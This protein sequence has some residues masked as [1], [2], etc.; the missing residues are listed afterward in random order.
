[1]NFL[2]QKRKS[3][4]RLF[5]FHMNKLAKQLKLK[6]THFVNTHGLMN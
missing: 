4:L 5:I 6:H 2:T 1:M 3:N